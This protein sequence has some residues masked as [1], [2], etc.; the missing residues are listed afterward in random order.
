VLELRA[1]RS[2]NSAES[3]QEKA[4]SY[5]LAEVALVVLATV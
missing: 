5:T 1:E 4:G 2:T 3:H